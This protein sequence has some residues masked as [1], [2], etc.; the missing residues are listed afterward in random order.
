V[1]PAAVDAET[2]L[3]HG[4]QFN[5][6]EENYP[7]SETPELSPLSSPPPARPIPGMSGL[8]LGNNPLIAEMVLKPISKNN[9]IVKEDKIRRLYLQGSSQQWYA[10]QKMNFESPVSEDP[11]NR[12][13]WIKLTQIFY[14][15]EKMGLNVI[16]NMMYKASRKLQSE[17]IVSYLAVQCHDEARH[18]FVAENYLKKLGAPPVYDYKFHVLGQVASMGAFR[19]ENW[20]FSTLFSENFASSFLRRSKTAQID[21]FGSE[22]CRNLIMDESRHLH[23]LNIV[24]PDVMDRLNVISRPYVKAS[25]YFIMKFTEVMS[26][27]LEADAAYVGLNRRDLLEE[28]FENMERSYEGFGVSRKW[29]WFPKIRES[30]RILRPQITAPTAP[31][32]QSIN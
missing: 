17:E 9:P 24:L 22:M 8:L 32:P 7:Q 20:L 2:G 5:M 28:V 31:N 6:M 29:L 3:C 1:K 11:E 19:V 10:L 26:R 15:L 16:A 12:R 18:V 21:P 25:Q 13:V 4:G 14:T 23:F 30:K 27:S